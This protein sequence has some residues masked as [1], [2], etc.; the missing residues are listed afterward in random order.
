MSPKFFESTLQE[1]IRLTNDVYEFAFALKQPEEIE[2]KAGQFINI[3]VDDGNKKI[4]FRSYSILSKTSE[5]KVIRSC[6]KIVREG[7]CTEWLEKIPLGTPVTFMGPI[8]MFVCKKESEKNMLFIATGTGITPLLCM[9]ED[10]L[11]NG[12][13]KSIHLLWGFRNE[14]HIFYQ[15]RLEKLAEQYKNFTYEITLSQP[16]ESWKGARGR[17]TEQLE[18][19]DLDKE[20]TDVYICG[21]GDMVLDVKNLCMKKEIPAESI[22]FERYD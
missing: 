15:E 19:K 2:F 10:E 14:S 9:I 7:R 17:V 11:K 5:K 21:L 13:K 12:Q 20:K 4:L 18:K 16:S 6:I 1:R 22:H 3:R 8:G